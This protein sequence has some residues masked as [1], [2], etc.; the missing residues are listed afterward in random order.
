[1][2]TN[3]KSEKE[4]MKELQMRQLSMQMEKLEREYHEIL[5]KSELTHEQIQTYIEDPANFSLPIWERLKA[6]QV[7]LDQKLDLAEKNVKDTN[8]LKKIFSERGSIRPHWIFVR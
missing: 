6:E 1:M 2:S 8:K 5:T 4:V 7:K 3:Q